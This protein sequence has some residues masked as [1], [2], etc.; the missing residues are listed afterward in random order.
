MKKRTKQLSEVVAKIALKA[1]IISANTT[2][3][4]YAHQPKLPK[5]VKALRK[6]KK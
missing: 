4:Y 3:V 2:C 5:S 6:I 1:A